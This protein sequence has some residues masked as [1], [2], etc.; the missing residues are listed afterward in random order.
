MPS[1]EALFN[2]TLRSLKDSA[3]DVRLAGACCCSGSNPS[4]LPDIRPKV[5]LGD[6]QH[7]ITGA[8]AGARGVPSNEALFI[9]TLRSLGDSAVDAGFVVVSCLGFSRRDKAGTEMFGGFLVFEL[10]DDLGDDM[11]LLADVD[12]WGDEPCAVGRGEPT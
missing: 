9:G 1:Y 6:A 7:G 2:G 11:N 5:F 8:C 10:G 3:V 4:V 12:F